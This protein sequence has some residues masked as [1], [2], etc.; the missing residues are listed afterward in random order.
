MLSELPD[1]DEDISFVVD[2]GA[3]TGP[4]T[5]REI[6]ASVLCGERSSS[7]LV[8]WAGATD[9]VRFE[10]HPDL[11]ALT[12]EV[13]EQDDTL[14][15]ETTSEFSDPIVQQFVA[16]AH[17]TVEDEPAEP[18]PQ[19]ELVEEPIVHA[20]NDDPEPVAEPVAVEVAESV[21]VEVNEPVA[22]EVAEPVP[23]A[24][25]A[26]SFGLPTREAAVSEVPESAPAAISGLFSSGVRD[27]T[28]SPEQETQAPSPV[29]L[30]AILAARVSLES[31]G[32]RIDALSSATRRTASPEAEQS[33]AA[34]DELAPTPRHAA[35]T[36]RHAA[37]ALEAVE[38]DTPSGSWQAIED[39]ELTQEL[40]SPGSDGDDDAV[41]LEA[42]SRLAL[43]ERF[44]E[45]VRKSVSHQRRI[46][47][48]TRV[49][50]L[51][52][53]ACITA[54]ADSGFVAVDLTSQESEHRV[55]FD[56]RNDSRQVCLDLSPVVTPIDN[57]DRHVRF[58]LSLGNHLDVLDAAIAIVDGDVVNAITP[59]GMLTTSVD[60]ESSYAWTSVKLILAADDLVKDDYSVDRQSLDAAIAATLNA[61][62][63]HWRAMFA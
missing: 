32:A 17:F 3:S 5:L 28:E 4:I 41:Q 40:K 27:E 21:A 36:P 58:G 12:Q 15:Q 22:V 59:P 2:D 19:P 51:L 38:D 25:D 14:D 11:V 24:Q 62:E 1:L 7:V 39:D 52:L 56:H 6:V 29:A 26:F 55:L 8:W 30:D 37:H 60:E 49:D 47:W 48:I 13:A 9:W 10:D 63:E 20:P 42:S 34:Q 46:E 35:P 33:H 44:E 50:E 18:A 54:I 31:V 16:A 45:M 43:T 57:H 61:L 53:S 23:Q